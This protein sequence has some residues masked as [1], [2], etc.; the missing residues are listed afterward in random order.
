MCS[1]EMYM[2]AGLLLLLPPP[3]ESPTFWLPWFEAEFAAPL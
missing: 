2:E 3:Y 1:G